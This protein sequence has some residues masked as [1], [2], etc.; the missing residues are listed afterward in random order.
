MMLNTHVNLICVGFR[1]QANFLE[2]NNF[3]P[4]ASDPNPIS[5][6]GKSGPNVSKARPLPCELGRMIKKI[7]GADPPVQLTNNNKIQK[8]TA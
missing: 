1:D 2:V 8:N 5:E 6:N 4:K 7:H 3:F